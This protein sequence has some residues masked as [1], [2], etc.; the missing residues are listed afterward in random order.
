MLL[1]PYPRVFQIPVTRHFVCVTL[2][3]H[4]VFGVWLGLAV[5]GWARRADA[6]KR[7]PACRSA[8]GCSGV[9]S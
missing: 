7:L 6:R 5:R 4:A 2:A 1:T 9:D 8:L 3:A